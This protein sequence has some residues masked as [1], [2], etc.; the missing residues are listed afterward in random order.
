M[1]F[2]FY[3]VCANCSDVSLAASEVGQPVHFL[4][5]NFFKLSNPSIL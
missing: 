5:V 2:E 4:V 3:D 1:F